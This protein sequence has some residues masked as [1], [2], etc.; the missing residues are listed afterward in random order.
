MRMSRTT[1][2]VFSALGIGI[3]ILGGTLAQV[4]KIPLLFL[5]TIGTVL[6]AVLCGPWWAA[7]AG[8]LT[9]VIQGMI[10]S[11]KDIFFFYCQS[12]HWSYRWFY[13]QK[14]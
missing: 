5:D 10:T 1:M 11:P 3:N 2:M 7:A 6:V 9:N 14:V 8:T 12:C 4:L 13:R